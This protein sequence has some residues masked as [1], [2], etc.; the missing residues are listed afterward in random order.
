MFAGQKGGKERIRKEERKNVK[1][2]DD[3]KDMKMKTK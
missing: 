3:E 2:K 1:T